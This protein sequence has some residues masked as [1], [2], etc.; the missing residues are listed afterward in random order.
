MWPER[1]LFMVAAV[2]LLAGFVP[3]HAETIR[4]VIDN[5]EYTPASIDAKMGDVVEWVNKDI[6]AHTATVK[7]S[8]DVLI[9]AKKSATLKIQTIGTVEY[10]CRFHPN[11]KGKVNVSQ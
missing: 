11:M 8:W 1:K 6:L 4:V 2:A 9:P 3:V 10:Y 5:L 7:G